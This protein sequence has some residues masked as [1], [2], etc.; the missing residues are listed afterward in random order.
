MSDSNI[1]QSTRSGMTYRLGSALRVGAL[2]VYEAHDQHGRR[3][4]IKQAPANDEAAIAR[5]R[6][7]AIIIGKLQHSGIIRALDRGRSR[8]CFF[9]VLDP[10]PSRSLQQIIEAGPLPLA[11]G[12]GIATHLAELLVYLH[13]QGIICRALP[14]DALYADHLGR[15]TLVDMSAAWDEVSPRNTAL[16]ANAA[17]L[18][19][20]EAGG[21]AA[22]R[23]SDI[24]AYGILLFELFVGHPPF[25]G[26]NRGDLAL[27]HLLTPPPN[28]RELR[29]DAPPE[30]AGVV[31]RCLAK[32]L[33][34]RYPNASAL[35]TALHQIAV[36]TAAQV[37][38]PDRS[39][40]PWRWL[41]RQPSG[42]AP[43]VVEEKK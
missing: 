36:P 41:F 31:H 23:R 1:L 24:Y 10:P 8:A 15:V 35:L 21:V 16:I 29:T 39:T 4:W 18:S 40:T 14:P 38:E 11:L 12:L 9:L 17:Y 5:L 42:A 33:N 34:Q 13:S 7:E 43:A 27:Q 26:S 37:A 2:Y 3:C 32:S 20:E 6:Y 19:P 22:E 28:F 25:Q 30:L